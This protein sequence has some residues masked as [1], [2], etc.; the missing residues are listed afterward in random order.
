MKRIVYLIVTVCIVTALSAGAASANTLFVYAVDEL[1]NS[2]DWVDA[3]NHTIKV[4]QYDNQCLEMRFSTEAKLITLE[5]PPFQIEFQALVD[6][7]LAFPDFPILFNTA[8]ADDVGAYDSTTFN[9]FVCGLNLGKH[10]VQIQ[11][12]PFFPGDTA[13]V[14]SGTLFMQLK[15]GKFPQP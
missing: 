11:Y 5:L 8:F 7:Q 10:T 1:C 4:T 2:A 9:W 15:S 3:F 6:G 14:Q 13:C 12:R